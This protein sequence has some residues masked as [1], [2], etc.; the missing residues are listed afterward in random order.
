MISRQ[1]FHQYV[2]LKKIYNNC[3][4][5]FFLVFT[6][7]R[8]KCKFMAENTVSKKKTFLPFR[9]ATQNMYRSI[10]HFFLK[11]LVYQT[12]YVCETRRLYSRKLKRNT[13][14]KVKDFLYIALKFMTFSTS[15][16]NM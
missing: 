6:I 11:N 13:F 8:Q 12:L 9:F 16:G 7:L 1:I 14:L 4:D 2:K 5:S 15:F 3:Q 10:G